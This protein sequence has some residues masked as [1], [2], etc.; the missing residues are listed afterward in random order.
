VAGFFENGTKPSGSIKYEDFLDQLGDYKLPHKGHS[1]VELITDEVLLEFRTYRS[2]SCFP[3]RRYPV[4]QLQKPKQVLKPFA[5]SM[6]NFMVPKDLI[7]ELLND[8][9]HLQKLCTW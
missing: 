3:Q 1:S 5:G 9:L 4:L 2:L 6:V 8:T 7:L